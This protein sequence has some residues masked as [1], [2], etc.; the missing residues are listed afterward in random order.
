MT[1]ETSST[2]VACNQHAAEHLKHNQQAL[3]HNNLWVWRQ[4][5]ADIALNDFALQDV[6]KCPSLDK[7]P[8]KGKQQLPA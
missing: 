3:K 8:C 6:L 1:I 5:G 7:E 2:N 4:Q